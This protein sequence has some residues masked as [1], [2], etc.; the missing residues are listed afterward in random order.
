M[1][2]KSKYRNIVINEKF[3]EICRR[4]S[5]QDEERIRKNKKMY[6]KQEISEMESTAKSH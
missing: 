5:E 3:K 2:K 1:N 6:Q 4:L